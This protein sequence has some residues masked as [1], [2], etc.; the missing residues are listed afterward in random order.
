M[1]PVTVI[2]LA[3]SGARR[4]YF[5]V[6]AE[7]PRPGVRMRLFLAPTGTMVTTDVVR[8]FSAGWTTYV[9]TENSLYA[10][11]AV[12]AGEGREAV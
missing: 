8:V 1:E 12:E 2:R 5:G 9:E 4:S 7:P 11:R 6:L 3:R 10:V